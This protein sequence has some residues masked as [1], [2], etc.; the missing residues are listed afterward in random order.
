MFEI[1]VRGLACPLPVMAVKKAIESG[2]LEILVR[3]DSAGARDNVTRL[4]Q[5]QGYSQFL[6]EKGDEFQITLKKEG[7]D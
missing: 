5:S 7:G 4:A 6:E 2:E 3:V 1:D